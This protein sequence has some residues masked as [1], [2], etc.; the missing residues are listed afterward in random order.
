VKRFSSIAASV[1]VSVFGWLLAPSCLAEET[2]ATAQLLFE[3][4]RDLLRS[5]HVDEACPK[6]LESHRLGP[7]TGTLLALAMCHEAQGRLASAWAEYT[8]VAIRAARDGQAPRESHARA[9]VVELKPRL[10]SLEVRILA[11]VAA[12]AGL[13]VRRNGVLLGEAAWN[14]PMPVDGGEYELQVS[15]L[16]RETWRQKVSIHKERDVVV[17]EVPKLGPEASA[18]PAVAMPPNKAPSD[19][20]DAENVGV[21]K[22]IA[23]GPSPEATIDSRSERNPSSEANASAMAWT[24][25]ALGGAGVAAWLVGGGFFYAAYK[26]KGEYE[27]PCEVAACQQDREDHYEKARNYGNWATGLGIGGGALVV[28]GA[29]LYWLHADTDP[30]ADAAR[31]RVDVGRDRA[32]IGVSGGF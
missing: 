19:A 6:L 11:P 3:Q 30:G 22:A 15:A 29:V 9:K 28:T 20:S 16:Q 14:T 17:M 13:E 1:G 4:G 31:L 12:Y 24:G 7:A 2:D 18:A 23:R 5:G 26:Q 27:R 32:F 21:S 10:S 8:E 25:L